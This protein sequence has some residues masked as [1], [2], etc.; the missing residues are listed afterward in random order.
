MTTLTDRMCSV[1][2][3]K[4]LW[5]SRGLCNTH[6]SRWR[7]DG[8]PQPNESLKQRNR[9]CSVV[10]CGLKHS[11]NGY[12]IKHH[13]RW[14]KHG[15]P[16]TVMVP[17]YP[18]LRYEGAHK[19]VKAIK[20]S[21]FQYDCAHCGKQAQNW[22]YDGKDPDVIIE[23]SHPRGHSL[24]SEHY[25]PLCVKCHFAYDRRC[26]RYC[27]V[28]SCE[29]K[30]YALGLCSWHWKRHWKGADLNQVYGA[31]PRRPIEYCSIDECDHK[32][33]GLGLCSMHYQRQRIAKLRG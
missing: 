14:K 19:R 12:C 4:N 31:K 26:V 7:N 13:R 1:E 23:P 28:D 3:C 11:S 29:R 17:V 27:S 16:H 22:A 21:S 24:K 30:H 20:G 25:I 10:E 6:Y 2:G 18:H 32:R 9:I 15:S 8:Y 5:H 33:Y